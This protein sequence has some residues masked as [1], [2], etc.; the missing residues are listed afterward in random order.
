M[1][2]TEVKVVGLSFRQVTTQLKQGD[3]VKLVPEPNNKYDTN[4]LA[5]HSLGGEHLGYVGKKDPLRLRMLAKAKKEEL[6]LPVLIANYY[7]EG[8]DKLWDNVQEGDM[9]QLWLRAISK[10]PVDDTSFVEMTSFTGEQVMWSESLH[11]CTDLKGN[12]LLGGSTYASQFEKDFDKESIA[13]AFAKKNDLKTED[14]LNYWESL[15][16]LSTDYGTSIHTALEHYSKALKVFGH[17]KALPRQTHLRK[18]VKAFLDVSNFDNCLA[19]PLIT[20]VEKG[21]SG[22]IDNLRFV[23]EREVIV[24]DYKTNTFNERRDY[25]SKWPPKLKHYHR[26]LNYYGTILENKGYKV[27]GLVVWH[28]NDGQWDRHPL[29]FKAVKEYSRGEMGK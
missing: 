10:T 27:K 29:E 23:G 20:D 6:T 19:E 8:D 2:E 26:Q 12:E 17:D 11:I 4:A 28:W 9:V 1:T 21:M 22:W 16:D 15:A 14:V 5:I 3:R 7:K 25:A 24:E 18:A 13:K